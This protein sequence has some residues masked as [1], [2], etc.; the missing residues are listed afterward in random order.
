MLIVIAKKHQY[1]DGIM[2]G[3]NTEDVVL[4]ID[5]MSIRFVKYIR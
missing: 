5:F 3:D 1:E 2:I 4:I